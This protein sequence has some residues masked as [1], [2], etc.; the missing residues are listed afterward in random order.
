[1]RVTGSPVV[2]IFLHVVFVSKI[3][4]DLFT[5]SEIKLTISFHPLLR[6]LILESVHFR[7]TLNVD[8]LKFPLDTILWIFRHP[9]K[10]KVTLRLT[11]TDERTR[12]RE[13][14]R[15]SST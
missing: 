3:L 11:L 13:N 4:C 12:H 8:I 2:T 14:K 5:L 7:R 6:P 1:M 15:N 10:G 9:S